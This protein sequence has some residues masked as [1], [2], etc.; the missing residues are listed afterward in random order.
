MSPAESTLGRGKLTPLWPVIEALD[1]RAAFKAQASLHF[2]HSMGQQLNKH[3]KK[4]RRVA[5]HKRRNA[6]I[7][8]S[9]KTKK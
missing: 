3:I 4:K 1:S 8:A 7:K 2:L 6:R 9:I 5:Y